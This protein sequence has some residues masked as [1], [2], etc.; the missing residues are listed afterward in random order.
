MTM[1]VYAKSENYT[2]FRDTR[3]HNG[4][5]EENDSGIRSLLFVCSEGA[6]DLA[7]LRRLKGRNS[8]Q[9]DKQCKEILEWERM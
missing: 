4:Y 2:I 5:I 8:I 3:T 6:E 7:S 9:F 1:I